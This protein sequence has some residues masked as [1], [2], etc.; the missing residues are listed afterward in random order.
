MREAQFG[1]GFAVSENYFSLDRPQ[2]NDADVTAR[3]GLMLNRPTGAGIWRGNFEA[4]GEMFGGG[5]VKGP[6][7]ELLGVT[8]ILRRNMI[9]HGARIVPYYQFGVGGV[10]SDAHK[11]RRQ[12]IL[13]SPLLFDVQGGLGARCLVSPN[14]ALYLELDFR[15]L[16]DAGLAERNLGLNSAVG[17]L[18]ASY[19]F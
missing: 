2:L 16:S 4:L 12:R 17:W 3:L 13:G 1:F 18:G 5:V 19:F 14:C 10:Y 8:L 15:H 9:F 7:H 11:E 6:G